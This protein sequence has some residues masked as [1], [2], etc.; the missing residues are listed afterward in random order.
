MLSHHSPKVSE[1]IMREHE[2]LVKAEKKCSGS[3]VKLICRDGELWYSRILFYFMQPSYKLLLLDEY[4]GDELVIIVPSISVD[5]VLNF[6]EECF[7]IE[8]DPKIRDKGREI[9]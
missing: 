1:I 3:D 4:L 8:C 2:R 9:E 5:E 6:Y 7:K